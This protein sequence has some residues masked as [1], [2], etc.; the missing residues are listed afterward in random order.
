MKVF[1][2]L[3]LP[4]DYD[5]DFEDDDGDDDDDAGEDYETS[6]DVQVWSKCYLKP[7]V[8]ALQFTL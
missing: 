4:Q 1:F 5:E 7:L 8:I 6:L 2:K 3:I